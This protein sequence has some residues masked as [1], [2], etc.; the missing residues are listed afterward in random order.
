MAKSGGKPFAIVLAVALVVAAGTA[1][2]GWAQP[3]SGS[4]TSISLC[5]MAV[6]AGAMPPNFTDYANSYCAD[7]NKPTTLIGQL[8]AYALNALPRDPKGRTAYRRDQDNAGAFAM[9]QLDAVIQKNA[10][11]RPAITLDI[12]ETSLSNL[13]QTLNNDFAYSGDAACNSVSTAPF[14]RKPICGSLAWDAKAKS[15]AIPATKALF[16]DAIKHHVAV[17]FITGRHEFERSTTA[18]NLKKRAL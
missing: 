7:R 3:Q 10:Y 5:D 9:A 1:A 8:R 16:D 6:S 14:G 12:D 2:L 15:P 4:V 11:G 17:F 13:D 18:A